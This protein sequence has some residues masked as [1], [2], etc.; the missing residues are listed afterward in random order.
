MSEIITD[1]LTGKTAAGNVT[2][3]SE[4]GAA[5]QSLQQGVLKMWCLVGGGGTPT[6]TDS[7]NVASL[8]DA[9]TGQVYHNFTNSMSNANFSLTMTASENGFNANAMEIG[10]VRTS[11][12]SDAYLSR[13]DTGVNSDADGHSV[14]ISGDLA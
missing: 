5:T 2:I 6:L 3:T 1:K 7:L 13:A 9:G 10:T 12:I 4:G 8:T 11:S 14:Q